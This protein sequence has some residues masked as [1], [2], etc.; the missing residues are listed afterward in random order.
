MNLAQFKNVLVQTY[1]DVFRVDP[2][3]KRSGNTLIINNWISCGVSPETG[4]WMH[5]RP[6]ERMKRA[7]PCLGGH[8]GPIGYLEPWP[9]IVDVIKADGHFL[10]HQALDSVA[11]GHGFD[12]GQRHSCAEAGVAEVN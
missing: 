8:D 10:A 9:I 12:D 6:P 1:F 5:I 4:W 7:Y 3:I 2:I 11:R